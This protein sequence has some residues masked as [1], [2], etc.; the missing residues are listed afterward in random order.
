MSL[1]PFD[2][3]VDPGSTPVLELVQVQV[4]VLLLELIDRLTYFGKS[5][6][7]GRDRTRYL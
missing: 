7:Q 6:S 1:V 5:V 4:Q 2:A 3:F